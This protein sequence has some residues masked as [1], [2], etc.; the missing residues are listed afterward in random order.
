MTLVIITIILIY[1]V[2]IIWTVK[3]LGYMEKSKKI[4]Y[5]ISGL[6]ITYIL[7]LIIFLISKGEIIYPNEK[8]EKVMQNILVIIFAGVNACIIMPYI[9]KI[10]DKINERE[11]TKEELRNRIIIFILILIV[12]FVFEGNYMNSIQDGILS[13]IDSLNK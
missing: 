10:I 5:I 3:N 8:I 1:I 2:L 7:T 11:I 12:I 4:I 6:I 9:A 13:V